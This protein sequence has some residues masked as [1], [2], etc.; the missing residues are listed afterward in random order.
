M[1]GA[2]QGGSV[3]KAVKED[4]KI[5]DDLVLERPLIAELIDD[6]RPVG[7]R[8]PAIPALYSIA[9]SIGQ[10]TG[11]TAGSSRAGCRYSNAGEPKVVWRYI[12]MP[13]AGIWYRVFS[14][15]KFA[16]KS[17]ASGEIP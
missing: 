14:S 6:L 9:E 1:N 11:R 17:N 12:S 4:I 3:V 8:F 5:P 10:P 15:Q 16:L 2:R 7:P 13:M